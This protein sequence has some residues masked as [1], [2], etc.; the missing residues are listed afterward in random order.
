MPGPTAGSAM[1]VGPQEVS[2]LNPGTI[3]CDQ[4]FQRRSYETPFGRGLEAH[5]AVAKVWQYVLMK[6]DSMKMDRRAAHY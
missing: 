4:Y 6:H 5:G 2:S 1:P 3:R